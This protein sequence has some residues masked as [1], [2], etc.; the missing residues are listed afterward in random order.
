MSVRYSAA[1]RPWLFCGNRLGWVPL[2]VY[3]A[4]VLDAGKALLAPQNVGQQGADMLL[5]GPTGRAGGAGEQRRELLVAELVIGERTAARLE[6]NAD[7][8][9]DAFWLAPLCR[10]G[11]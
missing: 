9:V 1:A 11:K 2:G 3:S 4:I 6:R 5:G 8:E 10:K 7:K